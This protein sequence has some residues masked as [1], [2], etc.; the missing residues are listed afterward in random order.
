MHENIIVGIDNENEW[1]IEFKTKCKALQDDGKC[2]IYELRPQICRDY[3]P[4]ECERNGEG[5]VWK[6]KFEN[7]E[8]FLKYLEKAN[9]K[10]HKKIINTKSYK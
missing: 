2:S 1:Y 7:R 9:P 8:D 3:D 10:M 6:H 4:E 5:S